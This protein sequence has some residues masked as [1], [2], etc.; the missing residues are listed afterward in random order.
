VEILIR[1]DYDFFQGTLWRRRI[2]ARMQAGS[3]SLNIFFVH[4]ERQDTAGQIFLT[5]TKNT[6][7]TAADFARRVSFAPT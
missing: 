2:C 7:L 4:I 5:C 6:E 3:E 1:R